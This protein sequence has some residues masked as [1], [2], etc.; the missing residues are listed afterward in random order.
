MGGGQ[1]G[2]PWHHGLSGGLP[3]PSR[4]SEGAC[5]PLSKHRG[6]MWSFDSGSGGL[7]QIL[8][9]TRCVRACV[10]VCLCVRACVYVCV[11]VCVCVCER[12]FTGARG[13]QGRGLWGLCKWPRMA[14]IA[15]P[16]CQMRGSAGLPPLDQISCH[17]KR[18]GLCPCWTRWAWAEGRCAVCGPRALGLGEGPLAGS[19]RPGCSVPGPQGVPV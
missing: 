1:Q 12:I 6:M 4:P 9:L 13:N 15:P 16:G 3:G 7:G 11:C 5:L 18:P 17:H 2:F 10:H 14:N 19:W 8:G